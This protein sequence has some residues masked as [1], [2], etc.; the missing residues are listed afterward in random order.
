MSLKLSKEST[1]TKSVSTRI[2]PDAIIEL[3]HHA[4]LDNVTPSTFIAKL[5]RA[6]L[7]RRKAAADV[8]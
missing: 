6:E 4:A 5:I 1:L 8:S 7:Q 3:Q 2:T